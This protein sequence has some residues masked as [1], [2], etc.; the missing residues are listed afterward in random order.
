MIEHRPAAGVMQVRVPIVPER[1]RERS[2]RARRH[3]RTADPQHPVDELESREV[4]LAVR[5][6]GEAQRRDRIAV[7]HLQ[8]P[9]GP[10]AVAVPA[11]LGGVGVEPRQLDRRPLAEA[12]EG[13]MEG[14]RSGDLDRTRAGEVDQLRLGDRRTRTER[15]RRLV[16]DGQLSPP[17]Q[18]AAE[19]QR[20]GGDC[21][22]AR[23]DDADR[24]PRRAVAAHVIAGQQELR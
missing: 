2:R 1:R 9:A 21:D 19:G 12:R 11:E 17:G 16:V 18:R 7:D 13:G 15:Q 24:E 20:S 14:R 4:G 23:V 3:A 22:R 10:V 5:A 8:C 6:I